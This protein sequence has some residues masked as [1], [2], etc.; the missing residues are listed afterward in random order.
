[1]REFA[2][3]ARPERRYW[4]EDWK[5]SSFERVKGQA[6]EP[7]REVQGVTLLVTVP[8]GC[9][10]DGPCHSRVVVCDRA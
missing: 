9:E 5:E 8:V 7:L 10:E 3:A 4:T 1:M 2:S 6:Y